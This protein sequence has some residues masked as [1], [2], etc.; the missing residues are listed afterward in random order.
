MP[1][2]L[3]CFF[4]NDFAWLLVDIFGKKFTNTYFPDK[5]NTLGIFFCRRKESTGLSHLTNRRLSVS[6]KWK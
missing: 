6:T 5:T 1:E 3:A 2:Y 4:I